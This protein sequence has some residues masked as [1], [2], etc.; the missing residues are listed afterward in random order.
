MSQVIGITAATESWLAT[1]SVLA[2]RRKKKEVTKEKCLT[3]KRGVIENCVWCGEPEETT[4]ILSGR[5]MA[6]AQSSVVCV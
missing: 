6:K 5:A 1:G 2:E 3:V 4:G